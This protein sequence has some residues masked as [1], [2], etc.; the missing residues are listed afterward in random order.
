MAPVIQ[1]HFQGSPAALIRV[2]IRQPC[3]MTRN[4]IRRYPA[5]RAE[6]AYGALR[7]SSRVIN[8]PRKTF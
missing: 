6:L 7:A 3:V 2:P 4:Q 8:A 1:T 5:M